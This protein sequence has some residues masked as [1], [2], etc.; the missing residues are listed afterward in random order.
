MVDFEPKYN[1]LSKKTK[2]V[3]QVHSILGYHWNNT[4]YVYLHLAVFGIIYYFL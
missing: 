4:I 2:F 3:K 1:C